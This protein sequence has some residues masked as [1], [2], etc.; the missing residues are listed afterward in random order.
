MAFCNSCGATLTDGT[1]FCSKCGAAVTAPVVAATSGFTP[2]TAAPV[3]PVA[4]TPPPSSGGGGGALKV[5]LIILGILVLLGILGGGAAIYGVYRV[6]QAVKNSRVHQDG[7]DVKVE[8]PFGTMQSTKD[9][10]QAVK[11]LGVD[12]YPGAEVQKEGASSATFGSIHTVSAKFESSDSM[13]K[14][15]SFYKEKFPSAMSTSSDTNRC[16]IVSNDQK[17]MV[18]IHIEPNG[19]GSKFQITSVNRSK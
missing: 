1:K 8:T 3:T 15:C 4:V 9:P 12:V 10:D 13:D 14:V 6:K 11:D 17:N 7:D 16:T 19:D 18:T 5:I 2:V